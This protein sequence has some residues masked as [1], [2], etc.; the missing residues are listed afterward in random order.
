[1]DKE[2]WSRLTT[3]IDMNGPCHGTWKD[4]Y[5]EP[6]PGADNERRWELAS[7]YGGPSAIPD[8]I[9]AADPYDETPVN[10]KSEERKKTVLPAK[11]FNP[12]LKFKSIE[13]KNGERIEL[14]NYGEGYWM[15]TCEISNAQFR[16]FDATHDS[17]YFG[18]R[19]SEESNGDGKGMSLNEEAQPAVRVSWNR[20]M[21]F[22]KW[23]SEETGMKISLPSAEQWE[24][25]CLAGNSGNF[26]YTGADFSEFENMADSTFATYGYR[27]KSVHG[28]FE[29]AL[30]VDLVVS[31]GVDL[32]NKQFNDG[33][34]VTAPVGS[35]KANAFGLYD[36]HGNAAEW[37][38][39][40]L[41]KEKVVKGGSYLDRPERCRAELTHSYPPWQNV[42]NTGFRIVVYEK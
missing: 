19:H 27:G 9:P 11:E 18:K 40:E 33:A 13:L 10:F 12:A 7:L 38:N 17:R 42:Y 6:L 20:A 39:T 26:H 34:C 30:D 29:V 25:A 35:Y 36:M 3:W 8:F 4:V 41:L 21:E 5:N 24:Y 31:E 15:G 23:L 2:S 22:C 37:T 28:H 32:A 1:M 14:V 16:L